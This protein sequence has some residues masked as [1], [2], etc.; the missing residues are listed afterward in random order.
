[1][2]DGVGQVEWQNVESISAVDDSLE[3]C[4]VGVERLDA[5][6]CDTIDSKGPFGDLFGAVGEGGWY[7][8]C[9][10]NWSFGE[11]RVVSTWWQTP[12]AKVAT[13]AR[14]SILRQSA[15][16]KAE[17]GIYQT[18]FVHISEKGVILDTI[19]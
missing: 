19:Q 7:C 16:G 14:R 9:D 11:V 3:R 15:D 2:I 18:L 10:L 12:K 1:M 13:W 8:V 4:A 6:V 17:V 5:A